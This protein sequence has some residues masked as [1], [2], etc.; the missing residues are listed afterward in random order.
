MPARYTNLPRLELTTLDGQLVALRD[1]PQT[2]SVLIIGTALDGPNDRITACNSAGDVERIFGPIAFNGAYQGVSGEVAGYSGNSLIKALREVQAAGCADIRLLRIGGGFATGTLSTA[3]TG[4]A[5]LTLA[6]QVPGRIYNQV[7]VTFVSGATS[8]Y[9]TVSQPTNKGGSFTVTYSL[10]TSGATLGQV[11]DRI[12]SNQSNSTLK[13]TL[14]TAV[15]T[16]LA[17]LCQGSANLGGGSDGTINDDLKTDKGA[18]YHAL[19][20]ASSGHFNDLLSDYN[21]DIMYIAGVYADDMVD[22]NNPALS[23]A[24]DFA[25]YLARRTVDFPIVGVMGTRPLSSYNT[26]ADVANHFQA[27]TAT[28]AATR[29]TAAEYW[30]KMGYFMN[31]GFSYVDGSLEQVIDGGAYLTIVAGDV[32]MNDPDLGI[33]TDTAASLYAGS[34]SAQPAH[35]AMT[36]KLVQ[37]IVGLPWEFNKA[38]LDTLTGGI[39]QDLNA[40]R[41]GKGAYV[42]LRRIDGRGI[43]FTKDV[44]AADRGSDFKVLQTLRVVNAAHKGI[45]SVAWDFLG[46][47]NDIAHRQALTTGIKSYLDSMADAGALLGKDG[48]GYFVQ[49]SGGDTPLSQLLGELTIDVTLRTAQQ[50]QA[51][52]V[53]IRLSL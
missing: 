3:G 49:V 37:N 27:L 33:Y 44:T 26:R 4:T 18:F 34:M 45:R 15:A 39:G 38:Q 36:H 12:N 7:S 8:G 17:R 32:A 13:V 40:G 16:T 30:E 41:K 22:N 53:R 52:K 35:Q 11:I 25:S 19:V 10:E 6:S 21:C 24:Q 5:T 48:I 20:D 1:R 43:V 28:D 23:L 42:T 14:G 31:R 9:V 51:I 2:E 50:I 47:P 29:A 46:Q